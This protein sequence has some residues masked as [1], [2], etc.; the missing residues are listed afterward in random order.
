MGKR[1]RVLGEQ[2]GFIERERKFD[3]ASYAK[4]LVFGWLGNPEATLDELAQAAGVVGV[5]ISRQGLDDRFS[6]KSA[7]LMKA[8]L[9]ETL[10]ASV[11]GRKVP[12]K[13][14]DQ[15]KGV[16][17][18]DSSIIQFPESLIHIWRGSGGGRP[19]QENA[20]V[21]LSL[22]WEW[23]TGKL[24]QVELQHAREHDRQ[25]KVSALD[26]PTGSLRI[27]DLGYFS[28]QDFETIDQQGSYWLSRYKT[29]TRVYRENGQPIDLATYL[30]AFP[31]DQVQMTVYL[32]KTHR[33]K[34][35]LVAYRLPD[36]L[37][38]QRREQLQ[39]EAQREGKTLSRTRYLLAAWAI[40]LTNIPPRLATDDQLFVLYRVR[41]QIE[42]LFK[43]WKSTG[44]LDDWRTANPWR[45]LTEFYAKLVALIIQHWL[46]ITGTWHRPERSL[47]QAVRVVHRL[48]WALAFLLSLP[49]LFTLF[50]S[51]IVQVLGSGCRISKQSKEPPT[52]QLLI[53]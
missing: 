41:W 14:L 13:L 49:D 28:L 24:E 53:S 20:G 16:Y 48:A 38:A 25:S 44:L 6:P 12:V 7:A 4:T 39:K 27:A 19:G 45:I 21:K 10:K 8:V 40:V 29:N 35:R 23:Q 3:G 30:N 52:F 32:G 2:T 22:R 9:A 37:V 46:L 31:A 17:L 33:V 50:L 1:A 36:D 51:L 34:T 11:S 18:L 26:L 15:F 42:L 47:F 5:N 43:L